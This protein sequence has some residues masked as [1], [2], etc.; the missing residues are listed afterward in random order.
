MGARVRAQDHIPVLDL[1][2]G[3]DAPP[4]PASRLLVTTRFRSML[5]GSGCFELPLGLLG[6]DDAAALL[7]R[8]ADLDPADPGVRPST[9]LVLP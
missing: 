8:I 4:A 9:A 6:A 2:R 5:T 7:F 1:L 3:G